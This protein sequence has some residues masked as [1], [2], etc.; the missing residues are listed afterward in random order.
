MR[1]TELGNLETLPHTT[2]LPPEVWRVLA[3][4]HERRNLAEYEGHLERDER[5]L[6]DLITAAKR[7]SDAVSA[8]PLRMA[9]PRG[10]E[11]L[12]PP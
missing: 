1:S 9:S 11:P 3:K 10:F 2:G 6:A 8:L 4:A 5:L 7:L 12:S